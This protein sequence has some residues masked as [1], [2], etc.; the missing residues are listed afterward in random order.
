[1]IFPKMSPHE[2]SPMIGRKVSGLPD[3]VTRSCP[4]VSKTSIATKTKTVDCSYVYDHDQKMSA[5]LRRQGNLTVVHYYWFDCIIP[6]AFPQCS[7][8]VCV[9]VEKELRD[10]CQDILDVLDKHLIP[11]RWPH[12]QHQHIVNII[13]FTSC[14]ELYILSMG[15]PEKPNM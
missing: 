5:V 7:R 2:I 1:M 15:L 6:S 12:Y 13:I 4:T 11:S 14:L 9:Q 10:I 8:F 3:M